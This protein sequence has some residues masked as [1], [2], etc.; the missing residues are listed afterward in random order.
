MILVKKK[1]GFVL[2]GLGL[3]LSA[4]G[5]SIYA[6]SEISVENTFTTGIVDIELEEFTLENGKE[7][8]WSDAYQNILPGQSISKIP[9][10]TNYG[11]DCYIRADICFV[12][13]SLTEE[14]LFGMPSEW[15]LAADGFY[16]YT[17]ILSTD[18][19]IDLFQGFTVP[20]DL[21][22]DAQESEFRIQICV[23]AVQSDNFKPDFELYDPWQNIEI[24]QCMKEGMYDI[25]AFKQSDQLSFEIKYVGETEKLYVNTNDF[26]S[27]F[28]VLLPGHVYEDTLEFVN[29][30]DDEVNLYFRSSA[31]DGTEL[32][33]KVMLKISKAFNGME[34][35]I[36]D[37]TIRSS[38]LSENVLLATIKAGESG[39]LNY[40][41][42]V[43]ETLDNTY[44]IME[45]SVVWIF[46]TTPISD[47]EV[48]STGDETPTHWLWMIFTGS[49][50]LIIGSGIFLYE[51][52]RGIHA[53]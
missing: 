8:E 43:P 16:Y 19:E 30:S 48:I 22:E 31:P 2:L 15:K 1:I 38:D 46:S 26:F 27:N 50:L 32:L 34:S 12:D 23:E 21:S 25:S 42:Y 24:Q 17:K 3:M 4:V 52:V 28:P 29:Q 35:V 49:A 5:T 39:R 14:T 7:V 20:D 53:K 47:A 45:D 36:Y 41:I 11:N 10:I 9:R 51:K 37:D 40:E 33:D 13:T 44:T 18:E 6:Y